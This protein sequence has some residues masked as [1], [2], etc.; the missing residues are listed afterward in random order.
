M[1]NSK[2]RVQYGE[3]DEATSL[4]RLPFDYN[5]NIRPP[6]W[7]AMSSSVALDGHLLSNFYTS[8]S[9]SPCTYIQRSN[10]FMLDA[11]PLYSYSHSITILCLTPVYRLILTN[12]FNL[13]ANKNLWQMIAFFNVLLLHSYWNKERRW[14]R[15]KSQ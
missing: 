15:E 13:P 9:Y 5:K 2:W 7:P 14:T 6:V 8:I 3:H 4:M 11:L 10:L 12:V 1:W